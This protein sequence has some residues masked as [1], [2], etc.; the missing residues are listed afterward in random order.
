LTVQQ[1][2][3][4]RPDGYRSLSLWHETAGEPFTPR[5]A[6]PGDLDVDV[7]IVGAGF[8][9]LWTAYYLLTQQPDLRLAV[10]ERQV[11]GFGASGRNGGWCSALFASSWPAVGRRAGREGALRLRRALEQTVD[12]VGAWTRQHGVDVGWAKGGTI[13]LARSPAQ[14]RALRAELAVERDWGGD[15]LRWLSAAEAGE[16]VAASRVLGAVFDPH[17]AAVH[18]AKLVRGIARVVE[19]S[20]GR[21]YEGTA[22]LSVRDGRVQ[23]PAGRVRADTVVVATE[24]YTAALPGARRTLAPLWSLIVATAPIAA[25]VWARIGWAGRETLSDGRHLL[26][27]AQRTADGRIAFG[28][29]GAPYLFGSRVDGAPAAHQRTYDRL[30]HELR[31]MFPA[32]AD[33]PVTHRWAGVLGVPR[34]Y[35]P[36]VCLDRSRRLAWAGG[37]VGDGVGCSHLAGR[38]LADLVL[39][40]DSELI[41]LPWVGHRWP[42]WEPEP[43]RWLGI[44]GLT[45][46]MGLA[47][48]VEARTGR[49]SRLAGLVHRVAGG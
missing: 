37:Y 38:T 42:T 7:A 19:T 36:A 30:E 45:R 40:R 17:C 2:S 27:Y 4:G 20:G 29:R 1:P 28:G 22:A 44:R 12:D 14:E 47:D 48:T 9:G 32:L 6:L 21:I 31:A 10:L 23:T 49:P 8:T 34:D 3:A 25:D 13:R 15:D 16:R 43:A 24:G 5:P 46:L 33:T 11:A 26:V 39:G 35:S 18:P 41:R